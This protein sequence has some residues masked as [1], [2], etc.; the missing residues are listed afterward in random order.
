MLASTVLAGPATNISKPE[1]ARKLIAEAKCETC[2][3][4]KVGGD[5]SAIYLRKDRRVT[6]RNMLLPKVARCNNEL[7][8]GLFPEDEA[9]IAAYLNTAY[10]HFKG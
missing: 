1:D 2:H 5:G 6:S 4:G 8:L 10:Y 9:A 3:M 7:G